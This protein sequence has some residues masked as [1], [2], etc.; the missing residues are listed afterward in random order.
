M[1][2]KLQEKL[3]QR[4]QVTDE[5]VARAYEQVKLRQILVRPQ[6]ETDAARKAAETRARQLVQRLRAGADFAEL[7]RR[8][9][10]DEATKAQGGELGFVGRGALPEAV[11]AV[12]FSLQPGA[13]SDPIRT[14]EGYYII[15][16]TEKKEPEGAEFEKA[17]PALVEQIRREKADENFARWFVDLRNSATI[18]IL[19]PQLAAR[20][21]LSRGDYEGALKLYRQAAAQRPDDAYVYYGIAV[22]LLQLKRLDEALEALGKAVELASSD[23][24]LHLA[25]GNVYQE[26]GDKQKAAAA[27]RKAS[28]LSPM[29]M[30]MHLTLYMLFSSMG[31][32]EDAR[33]EEQEIAKIQQVLEEQR[34]AQE[35][36]LQRLQQQQQQGQPQGSQQPGQGQP[37]QPPSSRSGSGSDR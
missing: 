4:L 32:T 27:L 25:L 33:R 35:E 20:D 23:P 2:E 36:F 11:E 3:A 1:A 34:R 12:A 37:S 29:D 16:V 8:E 15:Q 7:A 5:E 13:I 18:S 19:D 30:Q 21:A 28:S 24:M 31:F 9:S 6:Q 22:T 10:A 17:R 14:D 26:K